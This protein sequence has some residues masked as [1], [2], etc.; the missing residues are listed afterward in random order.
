[1]LRTKCDMVTFCTLT[2]AA[3]ALLAADVGAGPGPSF[4]RGEDYLSATDGP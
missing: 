2:A 4:S 3:G 1:M